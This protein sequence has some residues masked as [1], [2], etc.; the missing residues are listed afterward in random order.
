MVK[1]KDET[2]QKNEQGQEERHLR[3]DNDYLFKSLFRSVEARD[4]VACVLS[5]ITGIDEELL[6]NAD[7]IGGEHPKKKKNER[8]KTSDVIVKIDKNFRII[9]EL[10]PTYY[11]NVYRKSASYAF[12]NYIEYTPIGTDTKTTIY[13]NIVLVNI[14]VVKHFKT[15]DPVSVFEIRNKEG[16][17]EVDSYKSYHLILDNAINPEY[18]KDKDLYQFALFMDAS[19][20]DKLKSVASG[21]ESFEKA[22]R[23][24][25]EYMSNDDFLVYYDKEEMDRYEKE[26]MKKYGLEL[27]RVEGRDLERKTIIQNMMNN[28]FKISEI[29][30]MINIPE[31]EINNL[32]D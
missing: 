8:A 7:Y 17:L 25:E 1:T 15:N 18:N 2:R 12:A 30:K 22:F 13:P 6:L 26:E 21:N 14:D 20:M 24:V 27:G 3:M 19:D 28:G 4:M 23:K 9:V 31:E 16:E 5:K 29:S 32:L 11:P 10:N